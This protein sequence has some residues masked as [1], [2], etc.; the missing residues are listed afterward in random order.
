M[1]SDSKKELDKAIKNCNWNKAAM[2]DNYIDGMNQ[3]LILVEQSKLKE[4]K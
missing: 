2:M 4:L 3:I 1:I